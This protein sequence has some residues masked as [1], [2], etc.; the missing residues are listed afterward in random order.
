MG[1]GVRFS[2]RRQLFRLRRG[3]GALAGGLAVTL[4][5]GLISPVEAAP[6][7]FDGP[8]AQR[9]TRVPVAKVASTAT[10]AVARDI[11]PVRPAVRWPAT[12]VAEVALPAAGA[13]WQPAKDLPVRVK[14]APAATTGRADRV[15]GVRVRMH[16][17]DA[18]EKLGLTGVVVQLDRTDGGTAG[19]V[20][21]AIDSRQFAGAL[22]GDWASRLRLLTVPSCSLTT[23]HLA[24]C[25]RTTP[26]AGSQV[27]SSGVAEGT[28]AASAVVVLAAGVSGSSGDYSAS[29]LSQSATWSAGTQSGSYTWSYPLRVPPAVGGPSPQLGISYDSGAADGKAAAT[30]NQPSWLGEG[31]EIG[32]GFIE[33]RY[34]SCQEDMTDGNNSTKTGDLCWKTDNATLSMAGQGS[35]LLLVKDTTNTWKLKNEN[36]ARIERLFNATGSPDNNGEYWK[37][38]TADGTQ[39]FFGKTKRYASD[40]LTSNATLTAPVAGNHSGEECNAGTFTAS[41]CTQAWRWNLD[42][43]VDVHG[44]SMS[45]FYTREVNRYGKEAATKVADYDRGAY[46]TEIHYGQR[47]GS[48]GSVP[49]AKV[50]FDVAERCV[51]S[52]AITCAE[53]Q[54]TSANAAYWPDVPFDQLCATTATSCPDRGSPSFFTRKRLTKVTTSVL[55]ASNS[56]TPV[57]SWTFAQEFPATPDSSPKGLALN[58]ITH[59]GHVGTAVTMPPVTFGYE[60][61]RNRV[62][63]FIDGPVMWKPRLNLVRNETGGQ[64]SIVYD[65]T[66]WCH[67]TSNAPGAPATNTKKC[68]PSYWTPEG[69]FEPTLT[70]FHKYVVSQVSEKDLVGDAV[71]TVTNYTYGGGAAWRYDNNDL[72]R[73][74]YR[75]WSDWRGFETVETAR[76][77][78]TGSTIIERKK[79]LRG[80]HG[81]RTA[82][83]G[84]DSVSVSDSKGGTTVDHDRTN[85]TV[86]EQTSYNG[87]TVVST[88]INKPWISAATGTAANGETSTF[89]GPGT[90][91]TY[92]RLSTGSERVTRVTTTNDGTYGMT[93]QVDD[94]GDIGT[95]ADDRCTRSTYARNTAAWLTGTVNWQQTAAVKCATTPAAAQILSETRTLYDGGDH[96]APPTRGM[97]T[98]TQARSDQTGTIVSRAKATYDSRGRVET[99]TDAL[100]KVTRTSYVQ[101]AVTGQTYTGGL[102]SV[103]TTNPLTYVATTAVNPAWGVPETETDA[104][105]KVTSLAY[106]GLG[107]LASVWLPTQPKG[108]N[109]SAPSMR[110]GYTLSNT[111]PAVVKSEELRSNLTGTP[112]YIT[113][114]ELFD[115]LLRPKQ[116]QSPEAGADGGRIVSDIEYDSR[117]LAIKRNGP[118]YAAGAPS[119]GLVRVTDVQK[120]VSNE[121]TY[122]RAG[123]VTR[124]RFVSAGVERY[125][126][127]TAYGGDFVTIDP[128]DGQTPTTAWN[129]ARGL[130]TKVWKYKANSPDAA[131]GY[132]ETTYAYHPS[133]KLKQ[134]R[135]PSGAKWDYTYDFRG[136]LT[137]SDDPDKGVT[138]LTYDANDRV[139]TSR[140]ARGQTLWT[141]YDDLGRVTETRQNGATGTL[142]T[143]RTYDTLAKGKPTA[144]IRYSGGNPYT[145]EITG[146][147]DAYRPTGGKTTIPAAEGALAGEYTS[148]LT[149]NAVGDVT[150]LKL[151]AVPGF[152]TETL[153]TIYDDR[154][155]L[156]AN[157]SSN[158]AGVGSVVNGVIRSPFGEGLIVGLGIPGKAVWFGYAYEEGTRRLIGSTV[159]RETQGGPT[160]ASLRF[161]YDKGGN[162]TSI[163]DSPTAAGS[164]A[165]T[166]CFRHDTQARLTEAWTPTNGCTA[167][168]AIGA[169]GGPAGFW[170]SYAYDL[171]GNRKTETQ[172]TIYGD[173]QRAYT[174]PAPTATGKGRP[175]AVSQVATDSLGTLTTVAYGY[176]A[177]GNLTSRNTSGATTS[178]EAFNFN[179]EGRLESTTKNSVTNSSYVYDA[180]GDR[181]IKK[182]NGK[183]TLYLDGTEVEL[184]TATGATAATRYYQFDGKTVATR[185]SGSGGV[186]LQF[187][188]H[189]GTPIWSVDRDTTNGVQRRR[190]TPFGADRQGFAPSPFTSTKAF[191]NGD[192]DVATGL[193]HLGAREYDPSIGRFISVDP[194]LNPAEPQTLNSYAYARNNPVTLS[195]A[196]G[197]YAVWDPVSGGYTCY[198]PC[199]SAAPWEDSYSPKQDHKVRYGGSD[200]SRK[201]AGRDVRGDAKQDYAKRQVQ[202]AEQKQAEYKRKLIKAAK[203]LGKILM[204]ELGITAGLDCFTKGDLGACAETA[205]NVLLSA[206][207]G[208]AAKVIG[209]YAFRWKAG[210]R[211]VKSLW[212]LGGEIA[213]GVKG[214][215]KA[216]DDLKDANRKLQQV[217]RSCRRG[218][219]SFDGAT[220]VRLADGSSKPI[221]R[222]RAGDRVLA[223]DPVTGRT[224][225]RV[226][227]RLIVGTGL[228]DL[229]EVTVATAAGTR[230]L[231]ATAN[232]PF[233]IENDRRWTDA[234]D[235]DRGDTVG[236]ALGRTVTVTGAREYSRHQ[237][238]YNLTVAGLHTYYVLAGETPVLVHNDGD[239]ERPWWDTDDL[240]EE[241]SE[242][243]DEYEDLDPEE[244]MLRG[245][246]QNS[247]KKVNYEMRRQ[248]LDPNDREARGKVH[249]GIGDRKM[250]DNPDAST[251]EVREAIEDA[252]GSCD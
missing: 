143:K 239:D 242:Y 113:S 240:D 179:L 196:S 118:Y 93:T 89:T 66:G 79:Y 68:F 26:V 23:P 213:D 72:T 212:K 86:L 205:V 103:T 32:A 73:A 146:Y 63:G 241:Y 49:P 209:R 74:K 207:G 4:V 150:Q 177:T 104:N 155:G 221:S 229:V 25:R 156:P 199:G 112:S 18:A 57:D 11:A 144:S 51:P 173:I 42:Y 219:N 107:R 83:G 41:F 165:E 147:D 91:T 28:V 166:Q 15:P 29:G 202:A 161:D 129:D 88:T 193:T 58:G 154:L 37:L 134:I 236:T 106:D 137:Q 94:E 40:P 164:A 170:H 22:G 5:A 8:R 90:A 116:T 44:N 180:D 78:D 183:A 3:M 145:T 210:A 188:D 95:T 16:G 123:R 31:F 81:N 172:H 48:E 252:G 17:R 231:V 69:A 245:N 46:L 168:P 135:T 70:W 222:I 200:Y 128:P 67:A 249:E 169:V 53:S 190:F 152:A 175:H 198:G 60:M 2:D 204:D 141:G 96:G 77:N 99:S 174:S 109:P 247:K 111:A 122:D 12:G 80:M 97:I 100:G 208:F 30:N 38:T 181:L 102:V 19:S 140:D 62:E 119:G 243:A 230:T 39:Y 246:N 136:R 218:G 139:V 127:T 33:R 197:M 132:E 227:T 124:E 184:T 101:R 87:G 244:K 84:S 250:D 235:L 234:G 120:Q 151:P 115:G 71:D 117:G 251:E 206:I 228:K 187:A 192:R 232:H 7:D 36:G 215:F 54:L 162:V 27:A 75:T 233:W 189:Q 47:S 110:F 159:Q 55:T 125:V 126:T 21:V 195:D 85:G 45:Y 131:A 13:D 121:I 217:G 6:P 43:V 50:V 148:G 186:R 163:A 64:I 225:P 34:V 201:N 178:S 248:G 160:D 182:E 176:D 224:A 9:T 194:V 35:E 92:L 1:N 61:L 142:L 185:Q 191:V 237:T 52:G 157:L 153:E 14:R 105:G 220:R 82:S 56:H 203:Q 59:T 108:A 167:D 65:R 211:L 76:G 216:G 223:T 226:V 114:Y 149:Y 171:G 24:Q 214:L 130:T 20:G 98:E 138:T 133:D 10:A 238:V 158:N